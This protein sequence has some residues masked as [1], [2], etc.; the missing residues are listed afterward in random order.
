MR[1]TFLLSIIVFKKLFGARNSWTRVIIQ[2]KL[3]SK[4]EARIQRLN[5]S[6][7]DKK[8]VGCCK[9]ELIGLLVYFQDAKPK[10][11]PSF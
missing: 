2:M 1:K 6:M 9:R 4:V 5:F 11:K 3:T 10:N 8:V 7:K